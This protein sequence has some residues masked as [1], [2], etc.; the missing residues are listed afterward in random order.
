MHVPV[1]SSKPFHF[2]V[3]KGSHIIV[4]NYF[5]SSR[6]VFHYFFASMLLLKNLQVVIR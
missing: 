3:L 6:V 2:A 4:G 1:R 5:N